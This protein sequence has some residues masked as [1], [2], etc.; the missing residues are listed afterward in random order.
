M[1]CKFIQIGI[2]ITV[3]TFVSISCIERTLDPFE[4]SA[5]FFSVYGSLN[6]DE[7]THYIR[8]NDVRTP[9]RSKDQ[10]VLDVAV[11]FENI[12]NGNLLT[13]RDSVIEFSSFITHNFILDQELEPETQYLLT[14][15]NNKG[16]LTSSSFNTPG[17]TEFDME[18][19]RLIGCETEI[20]FMFKNVKYPEHVQMEVG[21][22]RGEKIRW[23][24][25]RLVGQLKHRENADE[26]YMKLSPRNL[27][28]EVFP[29]DPF[30]RT[31]PRFVIPEVQCG[32]L[33]S[34]KVHIRY[35]HFGPEW[36]I[37]RPGWFPVDPLEW[38][39]VEG[40]LGFLGAYREGSATFTLNLPEDD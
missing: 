30:P 2:V 24:K 33:E 14:V 21:F 34:D 39:D 23:A 3:L 15:Q 6:I 27:L 17:I 10:G 12:E 38:Q 13:L 40:G 11:T 35:K 31:N 9:V 19:K 22:L 26:M 1:K 8:V 18:P 25:V 20:T 32:D 36:D 28:V 4:D 7:Q 29:P 37:F 5:G 16:A